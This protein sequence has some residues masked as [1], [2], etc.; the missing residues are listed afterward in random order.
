MAQDN[1]VWVGVSV[2]TLNLKLSRVMEPRAPA[3][4]ARLRTIERLSKAGVPTRVMA[5]PLIP[6]LSDHELENILKA[7]RDHGAQ[8]ASWIM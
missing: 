2:T 6:A 5:S 1:L 7:G 3:P 8:S 4:A